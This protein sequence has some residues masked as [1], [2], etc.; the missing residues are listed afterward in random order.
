MRN[1][2]ITRVGNN[3]LADETTDMLEEMDNNKDIDMN[4]DE[5]D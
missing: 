1:K 3:R 2:H 5:G 4:E